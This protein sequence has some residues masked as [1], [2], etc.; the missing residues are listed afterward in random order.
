MDV[1]SPKVPTPTKL[2]IGA[3]MPLESGRYPLRELLEA[4]RGVVVRRD[5]VHLVLTGRRSR[6]DDFLVWNFVDRHGLVDRVDYLPSYGVCSEFPVKKQDCTVWIGRDTPAVE[7]TTEA[8]LAQL[9]PLAAPRTKFALFVTSF[10]P[11]KHEGNSALM[12]QYLEHLRAAG[13]RIHLVYYGLDKAS[14]S[15]SSRRADH[16]LADM[17][18][19]VEVTTRLVGS[20]ING[21]NVHVDDWC[22]GELLDAVERLAR[23]FEYDVAVVNYAFLSAT[24]QHVAAYTN[25]ILVTHDSFADRNRRM[26]EQGFPESGWLS[27]DHRGEA[28]AFGRADVVVALQD[29]EA[30]LFRALAPAGVD[31]VVVGPVPAVPRA[32]APKP[33]NKL[34]IG[35]VGSH[36]W[37]NEYNLAAFLTE[38][39]KDP[40]LVERTELVLAGGVCASL[41]RFVPEGLME[42]VSPRLLGEI[43][44]L[45]VLFEQCDVFINPERGGSGIKIKTVDAMAHGAAVLTTAAGAVGIT[46]R[47]RFHAAPNVAALTQLI[48]ECVAQPAIVDE[49]RRDTRSTYEAYESRN[50][51]ALADLF[52]PI[53]AVPSRPAKAHVA[54]PALR[55]RSPLIVPSEVR[56]RGAAYHIEE[57]E[58]LFAR[59]DV[60]GKRVLEI[61]SDYHLA[62][63]RL[64]LSNGAHEVVATNIGDWHAPDV[65]QGVTF[66]VGDVADL[67]L[68]EE[69]FDIVYGIA[70]LE[71]LPDADAVARAVR[72]HLK[73]GGVGYLQGCPLWTG[74][75]GHHVY[76]SPHAIAKAEGRTAEA[77]SK[78][79][80]V[81][82]FAEDDKNPIPHWSH[83]CMTGSE[84]ADFLVSRGLPPAHAEAV[85]DHV[86]DRQGDLKGI[87]SNFKA[88]GEIIEAFRRHL[89]VEVIPD[90]WFDEHNEWAVRALERFSRDD[91]E[92]LG[93]RFWVKREADPS[94]QGQAVHFPHVSI[95]IPFYN[96][97]AY[98]S[99]CLHSVLTQDF[100]D[101]E[102]I[103]VDDASPD[104]SRSIAE[105]FAASDD[106]IRIVTHAANAGLGPARNTGVRYARGEYI[107][108]LDSDDLLASPEALGRLVQAAQQT[109]CR[110]VVGSCERLMPDGTKVD[111][112]RRYDGEQGGRPGTIVAGLD[113]FMGGFAIP[114]REYLP[115]RAWGTLIL[116]K[117]YESLG[118]DY[119]AGEHEDMP[120]VPFLYLHSEG[121]FYDPAI[122]VSYRERPQSLS[123]TQWPPAKFRRYGDLWALMKAR[124][125][126]RG[127]YEQI[128]D[129]AA[130]FASHLMWRVEHCGATSDSAKAAG[131]AICA[132]L[133]DVTNAT[134]R[135]LL[136][137][138][139]DR[140]TQP[141]WNAMQDAERHAAFIGGMPD[142]ALTEF[143]RN[144][145]GMPIPPRDGAPAVGTER[146]HS[147]SPMPISAVL[148][149]PTAALRPPQPEHSAFTANAAREAQILAEYEAEAT[150]KLKD[151]PSMLTLGDKALYFHA[152]KYFRFRGT[153]VDGGCFV[154]GTTT[155]LVEGL[156]RNPLM[157][158][159]QGNVHGLI[160]VYDLFAIDDDY[161][162]HHLQEN[163]PNR[164]FE[165]QSSFLPIFEDNLRADLNI[166]QI[167]PGDVTSTGYP[168]PEP[169][170]ILGVDFCKAPFITDFTV[171]E[172]FPRVLVDGLVLQ[173]DFVHEF[174]PHIHLSMLRLADHFKTY[175]ELKW[176]GTVA[177]RCVKPVTEAVVRERFGADGSWYAD[178][179]TNVPLLRRLI[180]ECLHD[181]NRWVFLL[182]L[183]IYLASQGQTDLA[184]QTLDEALTRFPQFQPSELTRRL[185]GKDAP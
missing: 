118:L 174:H 77:L 54:M 33:A 140:M 109:G 64:F 176:G 157:Q 43:S 61:G 50:R 129:V 44:S 160:R 167:R 28:L 89:F 172:F 5:D 135:Q 104:G 82:S 164:K 23:E 29:G 90:R 165:T 126:D 146:D 102:I 137:S 40:K 178:T 103:L 136:F 79:E 133:A 36:N 65:P 11:G 49:I 27:L 131:E 10:H 88:P 182:T 72:R 158:S 175:V 151:F 60:R 38:W 4:F 84:M 52:G 15:E 114:E 166:L 93:L 111:F 55:H 95:I 122:A 171:R 63:A 18:V 106:R 108:F 85:A 148:A 120:H 32:W 161:I 98:F 62:S 170:E 152:A 138:I 147:S 51:D 75:L 31:V 86:Y 70:I 100:A 39:A 107:L 177:Y 156:R 69:G 184:R 142:W 30:E 34:R 35:Y 119:P 163:Y 22:G 13:Y 183:G 53:K 8:L 154:G 67:D 112:D 92:T 134:S 71:H 124:M 80:T 17:I 45:H 26:L 58:K 91:L 6:T 14:V 181:E 16:H 115:L 87:A 41:A 128:G 78:F 99:D 141:P 46:S 105:S 143:H 168:D 145:L 81:Y 1:L 21:L 42:I 139:L 127:L 185:I 9:G 25:K 74:A 117:C 20:N 24:F 123:S 121:V 113:A 2:F 19:E 153:I 144:R 125:A 68:G 162:L 47:S 57:F 116:R 155:A 150:S 7:L 132:I 3:D 130:V 149:T 12:R 59:I 56:E 76:V 97:E 48:A 179:A 66:R 37:V 173:Q 83:L 169:I 101:F 96:V 73:P 159:D 110:V 180:E 94:P